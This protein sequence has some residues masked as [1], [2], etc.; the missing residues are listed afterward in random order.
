MNKEWIKALEEAV[1]RLEFEDPE[2][3]VFVTPKS[4][5]NCTNKSGLIYLTSRR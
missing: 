5:P 2:T 4:R 1:N 3:L